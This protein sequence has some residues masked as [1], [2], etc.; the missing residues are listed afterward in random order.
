MLVSAVILVAL[1]ICSVDVRCVVVMF[2]SVRLQT[3]LS[4]MR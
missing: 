1:D 4:P 3:N 2:V